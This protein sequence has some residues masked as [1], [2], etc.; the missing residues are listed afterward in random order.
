MS[1]RL[2]CPEELSD[3]I[4]AGRVFCIAAE[5]QL[6]KKLP[7]G[8]WIGGSS[9]Y[10]MSDQGG[11]VSREKI[12]AT[13]LTK[14][15]TGFNIT[16]VDEHELKKVYTNTPE[17]GFTCLIL[18]SMSPVHLSYALNASEYPDFAFRPVIG[19]V[20]GMHLFD[21]GEKSAKVVH[22][23]TGEISSD[24]GVAMHVTLPP[25]MMCD[26]GMV[27]IFKQGTDDILEFPE[28]GF[29]AKKVFVNG[30][31]KCFLDYLKSKRLNFKLP[32][33]ADSAGAKVN[34]SF[35]AIDPKE[36]VVKFYA[37]VFK[38]A[39]YRQ[40]ELLDDYAT[41]FIRNL[42]ASSERI[43]LSFNC[44]LNFL[45]SELEGRRIG[46][47][48]G[49]VTFGEIGYVLLNQTMVYLSIYLREEEGSFIS[50]SQ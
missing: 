38:G 14:V 10:F 36:K 46:S 34:A 33:I 42:P 43:L 48:A 28:T 7:R 37:P 47:I 16:L 32:L 40:A 31:E 19:W 25:E 27:N 18:P 24:K 49:P 17:N 12:F 29:H 35:Q 6:L 4:R 20:S 44:I 15:T 41:E 9:P 23:P 3:L 26:I 8:N 45:Y 50:Q 30:E 2:Y 21:L 39:T 5:E 13:D 1:S 11:V 22:G